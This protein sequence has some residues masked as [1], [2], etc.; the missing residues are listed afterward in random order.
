MLG[1]SHVVTGSG[2]CA[3]IMEFIDAS[4]P[5]PALNYEEVIIIHLLSC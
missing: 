4:A 5:H 2:V 3:K 1:L